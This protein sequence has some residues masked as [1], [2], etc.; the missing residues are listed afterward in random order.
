[1]KRRDLLHTAAMLPLLSIGVQA[2]AEPTSYQKQRASGGSRR[3]ARPSDPA[4]PKQASWNK[5]RQDVGGNLTKVQPLFA[6][7]ASEP[8]GAECLDALKNANNPFYLG[9]QPGGT[10]VSGWLDAWTPAASAYAVAARN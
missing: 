5:L 9:D 4:W 1:M 10:Q 2:L 8:Q 3:R 6:N 7:C